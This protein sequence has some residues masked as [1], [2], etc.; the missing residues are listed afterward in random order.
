MVQVELVAGKEIIDL[1]T[2]PREWLAPMSGNLA[3][4]Y[5]NVAAIEIRRAAEETTP[6][7]PIRLGKGLKS[8]KARQ[9][10][11]TRAIVQQVNYMQFINDGRAA[12][13][14]M[15]PPRKLRPWLRARQR[16]GKLQGVTPYQLA[17]SIQKKGIKPRRFVERGLASAAIAATGESAEMIR[18]AVR[19]EWRIR[20]VSV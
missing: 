16:E 17:R 5:A 1:L 20:G 6:H 15:P 7:P 19:R 3:S 12:G 2:S 14:P 11:P 18:A 10:G 4:Q 9:V 8:I 13:K